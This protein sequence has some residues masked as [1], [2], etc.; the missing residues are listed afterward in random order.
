MHWKVG[1]GTRQLHLPDAMD[2]MMIY[3]VVDGVNVSLQICKSLVLMMFW[4]GSFSRAF[5]GFFQREGWP[6]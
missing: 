5:V 6:S 4:S 1:S 3:A 2:E